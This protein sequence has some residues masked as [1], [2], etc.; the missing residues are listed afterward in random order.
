MLAYDQW[1]MWSHIM[2]QMG[3]KIAQFKIALTTH[4]MHRAMDETRCQ[5]F[6]TTASLCPPHH[7]LVHKEWSTA[8]ILLWMSLE[9]RCCCWWIT[10]WWSRNWLINNAIYGKLLITTQPQWKFASK[11]RSGY[12]GDGSRCSWRWFRYVQLHSLWL[13]LDSGLLRY[14]RHCD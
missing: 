2:H 3:R 6:A 13:D 8:H 9:M 4:G 14:D 12:Y 7:Q 10:G 5:L 1:S 11:R